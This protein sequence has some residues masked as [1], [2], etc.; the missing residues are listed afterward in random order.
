MNGRTPLYLTL[1]AALLLAALLLW[2]QPYS[3]DWPGTAYATSARQYVQAASRRDTAGLRRLSTS[4]TPVRWALHAARMAPDSLLAWATG[5]DAW[6]GEHRGDTA[7]VFFFPKGDECQDSPIVFRFVGTGAR[8]R[9]VTASSR[10]L[11]ETP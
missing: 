8:A 6:V 7:Q 11:A 4:A 2:W 10:C 9:V 3:A 1:A 5:G